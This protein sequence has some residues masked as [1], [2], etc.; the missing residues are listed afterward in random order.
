MRETN[1]LITKDLHDQQFTIQRL[2]EKNADYERR[3][4]DT[5]SS[6]EALKKVNFTNE[7]VQDDV[8]KKNRDLLN[9][10]LQ[11][12][13]DLIKTQTALEDQQLKLAEL[14]STFEEVKEEFAA[15]RQR[16]LEKQEQD[17]FIIS[18]QA[19]AIEELKKEEE[20]YLEANG[21]A[22][23][24]MERL[25]TA[26]AIKEGRMLEAT[27][28]QEQPSFGPSARQQEFNI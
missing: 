28:K 8:I 24:E 27:P 16:F 15:E 6:L 10:R 19:K 20:K 11:L 26:Q 12:N 25:L 2:N 5:D 18:Q 21:I 17:D 1:S 9:E 23:K 3:F 13:S 14:E 4:K 22:L 7:A